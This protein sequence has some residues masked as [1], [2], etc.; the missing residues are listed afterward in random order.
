LGNTGREKYYAKN[1]CRKYFFHQ[2][3]NK[4]FN[5]ILVVLGRCM[6]RPNN[7]KNTPQGSN[8]LKN[9]LQRPNKLK[10][11]PQGSYNL[12][13]TLQRPNNLKN[14]PQGSYN[15]IN[16]LQRPNN[17]KN[18][19]QR[20][21]LSEKLRTTI[22]YVKITPANPDLNNYPITSEAIEPSRK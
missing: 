21:N 18:T 11:T 15:L 7:L 16:T 22:L 5:F 1:P 8:N 19:L 12:K 13:N 20:R 2:G 10:N 4:A 14:T 17:L 6:Q 3:K 9:T